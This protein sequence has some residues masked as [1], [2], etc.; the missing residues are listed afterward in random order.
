MPKV[1]FVGVLRLGDLEVVDARDVSLDVSA[2][3]VETSRRI[4]AGWKSWLQGWKEWGVTLD[5]VRRNDSQVLDNIRTAFVD[6]TEMSLSMLD[7]EGEGITGTILVENFPEA[8]PLKDVMS[9]A[10]TLKG[11]GAF[12]VVDAVS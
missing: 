8:Q 4:D 5:I 12:T 2:E 3:M 10:V 6:G 7:D 1:G 9:H 11:Q